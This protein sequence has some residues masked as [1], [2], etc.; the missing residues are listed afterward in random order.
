MEKYGFVYIWYDRKH[1]RYYVG[2]HWGTEDDGYI[3][4]STWMRN[5]RSR[6]PGDFKRRIIQKVT[7]RWILLDEEQKWLNQIK[8]EE[9]KVRYY[10]LSKTTKNPWYKYPDQVKTVSEKISH[11]VKEHVASLT[12]E[13]R[14][15][16]FGYWRG[17]PSPKRGVPISEE[18]KEKVRQANL[19]KKYS[20]ETNA[21]KGK[22]TWNKGRSGI[23]S[24]ETREKIGAAQRGKKRGPPSLETRLKISETKRL[25]RLERIALQDKG[26]SRLH[27][28][29][30]DGSRD[31]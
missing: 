26:Q 20:A 2:S 11:Q 15:E 21:K 4:S 12:P 23:Y 10:N 25:R 6:R 16:R 24:E 13:E 3:C 17:K 5:A 30:Q 19:G 22:N 7:D 28:R 29:S 8:D 1:N 31:K 18:Q 27:V 9:I 14:R